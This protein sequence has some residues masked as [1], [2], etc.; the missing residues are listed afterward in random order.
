MS[1]SIS[2]DT[3]YREREGHQRTPYPEAVPTLIRAAG[4]SAGSARDRTRVAILIVSYANPQDV[5]RCL[6]SI[7]SSDCSDFEV[8]V[9]ENAGAAEFDRLLVELAGPDGPLVRVDET[10]DD[11]DLAGGRLTR[12]VKCNLSA[13][14]NVVRLAVATENLGYGG[15][16][17]AWLERFVDRAN[18]DAVLVLNPDTEIGSSCLTALIAKSRE[19]YGMVG[20]ALVFDDAPGTIINYGLRWSRL[21]GRIVAVGRNAPV[22]KVPSSKTVASLDSISGACVFVTR[23]FIDE[24]GLMSEE[25]FLY[26]ED[27]DWGLRR[28][29]QRI[30]Y[31]PL[32]VVRH[33]C[34]T[35][36]GS[37]VDRTRQSK[38]SIYLSAR[39][40]ILYARQQAGSLWVVHLFVGLLDA[41]K[42][43]LHGRPSASRTA[44]AGLVHGVMGRSGRPD[45]NAP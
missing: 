29:S 3:S 6:R 31:A 12:V 9:C 16:I 39:N 13:R 43:S 11:L 14:R 22:D 28:G 24:V 44:L 10:T 15:G 1:R 5:K 38:L 26:M 7:A 19:G 42:Y 30:G 25:F 21:T 37:A 17:N 23:A 35:S 40:S 2:K 20:G 32:A 4:N 18:W 45:S 27:L 33:V 41:I 36:I 8:F 34:G